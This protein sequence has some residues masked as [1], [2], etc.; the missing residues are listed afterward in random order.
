M[1]IFGLLGYPLEHSFSPLYMNKLFK[2]EELPHYYEVFS[3]EKDKVKTFIEHLRLFNIRGINITIPY[4]TDVLAYVDELSPEVEI[5]NACN[6]IDVKKDK[7]IAHNTDW[8]GFTKALKIK[9]VTIKG[10]NIFIYGSGGASK[11]VFYAVSRA[12][13]NRVTF[14]AR[15]PQ[16][17][18]ELVDLISEEY[19]VRTKIIEW[20]KG[21]E[22]A[23]K[24]EI[25]SSHIVVNTTPLGMYPHVETMP[26]VP[27]I[28]LSGKIFFDLVYNPLVTRF[29]EFS[30][31]RGADTLNGMYMLMYQ[32]AKALSIW[33]G[34]EFEDK[35]KKV[36][37][38]LKFI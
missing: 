22:D 27:D 12:Q 37:K 30:A 9:G 29:L 34:G 31:L 13:A 25:L 16:K 17:A 6:V 7:L 21:I 20:K 36:F 14:L 5:M 35:V 24:D 2:I 4:K 18:M 28:D 11:S 1:S 32:G 15:T 26:P 3:V 38:E 19:P 10:K 8:Y 23:I 33:L